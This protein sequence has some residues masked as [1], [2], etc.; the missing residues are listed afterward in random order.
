MANYTITL[1]E[2]EI[3]ALDSISLVADPQAFVQNFVSNRARKDI[4]EIVQLYTTKALDEGIT[5]PGTRE[6]IVNDALA[7][8]WIQTAEEQ[9]AGNQPPE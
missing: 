5:I 2:A 8:G 4:D 6:L 3:K 7:R 1:N 9:A